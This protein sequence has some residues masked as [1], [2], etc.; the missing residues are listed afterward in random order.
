MMK[1][2]FCTLNEDLVWPEPYVKGCRPVRALDG[3]PH[4]CLNNKKGELGDA[5]RDPEYDFWICEVCQNKLID[6]K[7]PKNHKGSFIRKSYYYQV[8][9]KSPN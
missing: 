7:C 4:I 9:K 6:F 3:K 5:I 1:C 2:K 8:C